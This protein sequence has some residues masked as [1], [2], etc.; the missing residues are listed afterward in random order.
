MPLRRHRLELRG[1]LLV[2]GP[3]RGDLIVFSPPK[4]FYEVKGL[5]KAPRATL[6]KRVVATE[7]DVVAMRDGA[8]E[9]NGQRVYEPYVREAA[10]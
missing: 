4:A 6:I 5:T 8:L 9:L 10:R 2:A 3:R 1:Y 7:G